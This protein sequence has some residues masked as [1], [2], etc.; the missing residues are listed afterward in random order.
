[1][2]SVYILNRTDSAREK[3]ILTKELRTHTKTHFYMCKTEGNGT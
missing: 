1:M 2:T 3:K